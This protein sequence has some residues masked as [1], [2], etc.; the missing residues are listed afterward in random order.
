M[1]LI[2]HVQNQYFA[3]YKQSKRREDDIAIVNAA[4]NLTL[5]SE[6]K[7]A[8]LDMAFGGMAPTTVVAPKTSAS[9]MNK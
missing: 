9:L 8:A 2:L 7:V 5:S 6:G 4:F 1:T 3:A